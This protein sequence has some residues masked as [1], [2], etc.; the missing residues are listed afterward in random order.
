MKNLNDVFS[1]VD[2]MFG[3]AKSRSNFED[4]LQKTREYAKKSAEAIE[5]SRKKIELLDAKTKLAKAYE[6]FGKLQFAAYEGDEVKQDDVDAS[7]DEITL[8]KNKVAFLDDEIAAFK[9]T[10]AAGFDAKMNASKKDDVVVNDV[11][12]SVEESQK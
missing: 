9:E 6:T 4:V 2:E 10:V 11:E 5:I 8:L 12:V 1:G 3:S 7:I